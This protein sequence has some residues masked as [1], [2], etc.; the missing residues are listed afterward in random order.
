[1]DCLSTKYNSLREQKLLK[2][3]IQITQFTNLQAQA[4]E[5]D[6]YIV[7]IH[8]TVRTMQNKTGRDNSLVTS[9]NR[10]KNR[11]IIEV[12]FKGSVCRNIGGKLSPVGG[13]VN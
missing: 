9:N 10:Q 1:M 3:K 6:N 12:E 11:S 2:K 7:I 4:S 13:A 8:R 5:A